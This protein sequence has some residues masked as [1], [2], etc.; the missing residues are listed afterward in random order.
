MEEREMT[1]CIHR[2]V[3]GEPRRGT[4]KGVCRR[5]GAHRTYPSGLELPAVPPE[6]EELDVRL[7]LLVAAA[8]T[9]EEDA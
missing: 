3:L 6:A 8:S 9:A 2:W 7:P 4:I 1:P 5:C